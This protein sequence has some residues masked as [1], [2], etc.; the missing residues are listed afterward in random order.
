MQAPRL[1]GRPVSEEKLLGELTAMRDFLVPEW[2]KWLKTVHVHAD[3]EANAERVSLYTASFLTKALGPGWFCV[4]GTPL[5]INMKT[6]AMEKSKASGFRS[7]SGWE[8]H[9]WVTCNGWLA[10]ITASEIGGDAVIL[11]T[12]NDGRYR[13]TFSENEITLS[14]KNARERVHAWHTNWL[15]TEAQRVLALRSR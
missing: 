11:T 7:P 6:Y 13:E 2:D 14:K 10:D 3:I 4:G 15:E 12:T 5:A 9:W 1:E 8:P